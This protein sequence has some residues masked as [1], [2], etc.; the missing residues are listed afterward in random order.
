MTEL[1][2][3]GSHMVMEVATILI[4]EDEPLWSDLLARTLAADPGITI[5][6]Q[7]AR[8]EL[9]V[10]QARTLKPTAVLMDIE[11]AGEIDG[12]EAALQIKDEM[13]ET[14]I[15]IL[16]AHNDRRYVTSLPLGEKPG[17]AYL[18]KQTV[19]DVTTVVRAIHASMNGMVMLD[20]GV[21]RSLKPRP[22]SKL[23]S[24]T[25]RELEV[26][27]LMAQAYNNAAIADKL[28]L[29]EKSVE[30]YS[31]AIYQKLGVSGEQ[32]LHPRVKATRI[33]LEESENR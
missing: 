11:L 30:T 7:T 31:N 1:V 17:W 4:V 12:I 13:P 19:P 25:V 22:R 29:A 6:G 2:E 20:P 26:L 8:G 16:S 3:E 24:L 28:V 23:A 33:F 21:V 32:G 9:A 10:I 18:L 5:L 27:E 15:V 14:G